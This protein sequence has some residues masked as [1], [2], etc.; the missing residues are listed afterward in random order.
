MPLPVVRAAGIA[1]CA[2]EV[3]R[4]RVVQQ[5]SAL[6]VDDPDTVAQTRHDRAEQACLA[7]AFGLGPANLQDGPPRSRLPPTVACPQL[8]DWPRG[9]IRRR[10]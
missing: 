7:A 1:A 10:W 2:E 4:R 3:L 9:A 6:L 8:L 5:E